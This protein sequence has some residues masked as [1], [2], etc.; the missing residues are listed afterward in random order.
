[1]V[2]AGMTAQEIDAR[3]SGPIETD[4]VYPAYVTLDSSAEIL[5]TRR[6]VKVAGAI[7]GHEFTATL[8]PSGTGSHLLPLRQSLR[9]TVGKGRGEEVSVHLR[10]RYT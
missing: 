3:F 2:A 9:K 1:M 10:Q 5:G 8:M 6:P 7:D 4:G